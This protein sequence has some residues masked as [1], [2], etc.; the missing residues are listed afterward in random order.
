MEVLAES[1]HFK[2]VYFP[3]TDK[4]A[5]VDGM[6]NYW[7]L[8]K[9]TGRFDVTAMSEVGARAQLHNQEQYWLQ[10]EAE[11]LKQAQAEIVEFRAAGMKEN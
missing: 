4:F 5:G 7:L 8:N 2:L 10:L 9:S 6:P 1:K 11:Q 3:K